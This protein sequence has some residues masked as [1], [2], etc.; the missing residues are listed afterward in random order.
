[1]TVAVRGRVPHEPEGKFTEGI[2]AHIA[3]R[4]VLLERLA[5]GNPNAFIAPQFPSFGSGNGTVGSGGGTVSPVPPTTT[6]VIVTSAASV[7]D[8]LMFGGM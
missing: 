4:L 5:A 3:H 6:T 2:A 7:A 8:V 1:M